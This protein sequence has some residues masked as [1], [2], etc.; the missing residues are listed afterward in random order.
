MTSSLGIIERRGSEPAAPEGV[1]APAI[2][3]NGVSKAYGHSGN[4]VVALDRLSLEVAP[5]EFVC[6]VGASG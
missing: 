3:I 4:A 2:R 6:L 1:T 5:G